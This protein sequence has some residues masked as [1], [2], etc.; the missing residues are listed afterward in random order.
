[1]KTLHVIAAVTDDELVSV[2]VL[3]HTINADDILAF[4]SETLIKIRKLQE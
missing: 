3:T 2:M 4:W 1:M